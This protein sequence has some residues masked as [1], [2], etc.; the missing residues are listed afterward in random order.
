MG[1]S[2]PQYLA[3]RRGQRA[4]HAVSSPERQ[5]LER[6]Q[7]ASDSQAR[8]C[9][10]FPSVVGRGRGCYIATILL[11]SIFHLLYLDKGDVIRELPEVLSRYQISGI[12]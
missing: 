6:E 1:D 2:G 7:L 12:S 10:P 5:I 9:C 8:A 3:E 11:T 4:H